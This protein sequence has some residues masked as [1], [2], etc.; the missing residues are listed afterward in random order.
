VKYFVYYKSYKDGK[1]D[2]FGRERT[3]FPL[4]EVTE[5]LW[6]FDSLDKALEAMQGN[7]NPGLWSNCETDY[8][9]I[10][11]EELKIKKVENKTVEEKVVEV[12]T[13]K[14]TYEID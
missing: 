5:G 1:K 11:G 6:E 8:R 4:H 10:K 14:I 7:P 2:I 12:E 13:T 9:L 3:G